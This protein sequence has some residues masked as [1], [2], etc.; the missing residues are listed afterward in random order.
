MDTTSGLPGLLSETSSSDCRL[1]II[2]G[3]I[4]AGLDAYGR[5]HSLSPATFNAIVE[6]R[7]LASSGQF[8]INA[9]RAGRI[10]FNSMAPGLKND[11]R[12]AIDSAVAELRRPEYAQYGRLEY[13]EFLEK[14][15]SER[16]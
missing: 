7:T 3:Y 13:L 4:V 16:L 10:D 5:N 8:G 2:C 14:L 6:M 12:R 9:H 1:S 15:Q 11:L